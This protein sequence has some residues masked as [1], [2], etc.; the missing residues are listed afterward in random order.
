MITERKDLIL[1]SIEIV[2][3]KIIKTNM[4]RMNPREKNPWEKWEDH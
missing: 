4:L 2:L 3:I 1:F